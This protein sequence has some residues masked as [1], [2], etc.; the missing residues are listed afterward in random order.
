VHGL[1][2][3][4]ERESDVLRMLRTVE[5][6][7]ELLERH[8]HQL[9]G[10]QAQRVAL[11]RALATGP[12]LLIADEALS[13]LDVS[14]RAQMANLLSDL[15]RSLGIACLFVSHDLRLAGY[16]CD[17]LAVL[18]RGELVETAGPAAL[19]RDPRHPATRALVAAARALEPDLRAYRGR[20]A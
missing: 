12:S 20:G 18:H 6:G 5:L 3:G 10:G 9:S 16:L 7:P 11:A 15:R 2:R 17:R 8:P 14:L 1:S 19:L 4:R 13:A